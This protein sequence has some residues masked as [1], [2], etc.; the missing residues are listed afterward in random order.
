ME[1]KTDFEHM[2]YE[3]MLGLLKENDAFSGS[4]C[5]WAIILLFLIFGFNPQH[6]SE[7]AFWRGKYEALKEQKKQDE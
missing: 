2:D 7:S 3:G 6:E 1:N 4:D 5:W